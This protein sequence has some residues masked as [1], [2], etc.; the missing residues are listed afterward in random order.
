MILSDERDAFG[1]PRLVIDFRYTLADVEPL[2][3]AHESFAGWLAGTGLGTLNWSVRTDKLVG[4][5]MSQSKDGRHQI[6]TTRMGETP[7]TGIVD[8]DCRVFGVANLF[9]AGTSIFC[10]SG[11]ANPT[12]TAVAL[13]MRLA[14][15]LTTEDTVT[16]IKS[17]HQSYSLHRSQIPG[18]L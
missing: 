16:E 18:D 3:R 13:A 17:M 15:K 2:I 8:K 5:I 6:G 12:L 7:K 1:L 9:V 14:H 11:H 4:H 10:S